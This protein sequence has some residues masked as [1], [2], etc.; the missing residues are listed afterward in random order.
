[1][2]TNVDIDDELMTRALEASG[3]TT[4]EAVIEEGLRMVICLNGQMKPEDMF[5][6][7]PNGID[8]PDRD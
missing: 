3:L 5:G 1:M 4:K 6:M 2:H 8:H 7:F